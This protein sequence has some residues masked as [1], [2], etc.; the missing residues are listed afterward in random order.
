YHFVTR[1]L[2]GWADREGAGD[3]GGA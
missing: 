3:R 1:R 2:L